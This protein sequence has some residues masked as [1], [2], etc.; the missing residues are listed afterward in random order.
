MRPTKTRK[1]KFREAKII[2]EQRNRVLKNA[3]ARGVFA[4]RRPISNEDYEKLQIIANVLQ[5]ELRNSAR[6]FTVQTLGVTVIGFSR[7]DK[8]H[9]LNGPPTKDIA[10]Q[11]PSTRKRLEARLGSISIY[12]TGKLGISLINPDLNDEEVAFEEEFDR[13]G[14]PLRAIP[15]VDEYSEYAPHLSIATIYGDNLYHFRDPTTL[16]RLSNIANLSS[17]GNQTI[18]LEPVSQVSV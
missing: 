7:F 15:G 14:F 1:T 8:Y 17:N 2:A 13:S 3:N 10:I 4:V 12:A 9:R 6:L 16:K 18:I 11:I 5:P